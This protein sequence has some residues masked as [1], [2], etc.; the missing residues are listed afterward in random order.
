MAPEWKPLPRL[1]RLQGSNFTKPDCRK[2]HP[3]VYIALAFFWWNQS[4]LLSWEDPP[5]VRR[6]RLGP[7]GADTPCPGMLRP[8]VEGFLHGNVGPTGLD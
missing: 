5:S 7:W 8:G 4:P 6:G 1:L 3:P 2:P